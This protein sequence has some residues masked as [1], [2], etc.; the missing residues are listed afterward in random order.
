M[1]EAE[2]LMFEGWTQLPQFKRKVEQAKAVIQEALSISPAYVAVSWGKDSLVMAHL[3][4]LEDPSVPIVHIGAPHQDKLDNYLEVEADFQARFPCSY[5]RVDLGMRNAKETFN[6]LKKTL[7]QLAFIG[8]RAEESKHRRASLAS[9]GAVYQYKKGGYRACPLAWWAW[10]DV[11]AYIVLHDLKALASY[12]HESNED[13]SL[14]RTA[15]H[16]GR[17]RGANLGRFER[18]RKINPEY[19]E[20]IQTQLIGIS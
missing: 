20:L 15:V 3:V 17:G 14:S 12:D 2:R 6:S 10:R 8:L 16:V 1:D 19:Y 7:P 13:K 5:S 11:W 4:W 18:L 9:K